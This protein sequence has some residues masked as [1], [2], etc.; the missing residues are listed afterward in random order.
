MKRF[1]N[2]VYTALH[3]DIH[4]VLG[5]LRDS[6]IVRAEEI[7]HGVHFLRS[8]CKAGVELILRDPLLIVGGALLLLFFDEVVQLPFVVK[9]QPDRYIDHTVRVQ[10]SQISRLADESGG[11]ASDGACV[12]VNRGTQGDGEEEGK[13]LFHIGGSNSCGNHG[14]QSYLRENVSFKRGGASISPTL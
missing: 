3:L 10:R 5:D 1:L 13:E 11:V 9:L 14:M 7:L 6:E 2:G 4:I 12:R 8:R